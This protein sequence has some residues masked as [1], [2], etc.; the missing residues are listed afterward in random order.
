MPFAGCAYPDACAIKVV[1]EVLKG[2]GCPIA[3]C[4]TPLNNVI[5]RPEQKLVDAM[6]V[7]D[8]I[9]YGQ[10]SPDIIVVVS[11]DD[12]LWPGIRAALVSG[13]SIY[14][15]IPRRHNKHAHLYRELRTDLY[16]R[17]SM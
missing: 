6:L 3:K 2:Q 11:G 15:V 16:S 12:D 7:A 8:L 5:S 10:N 17:V 1:R 9:H 13:A 14:H 4:N